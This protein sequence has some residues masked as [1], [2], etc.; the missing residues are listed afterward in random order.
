MPLENGRRRPDTKRWSC[1]APLSP[2]LR[3]RPFRPCLMRA[4]RDNPPP[5]NGLVRLGIWE[6]RP[7]RPWG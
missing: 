7:S 3:G 5:R 1:G 6:P 4:K 2:G